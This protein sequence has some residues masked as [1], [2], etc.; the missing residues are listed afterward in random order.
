MQYQYWRVLWKDLKAC[1]TLME[2]ENCTQRLFLG[3]RKDSLL[4]SRE[5]VY[6]DY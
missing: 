1:K 6:P 3:G 4:G 5:V 2:D